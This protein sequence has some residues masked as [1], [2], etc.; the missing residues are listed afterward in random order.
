MSKK[1]EIQAVND[2]LQ[3]LKDSWRIDIGTVSDG[4]HT[5]TELYEHRYHLYI[6]LCKSYC[7][8]R[9]HGTILDKTWKQKFTCNKSYKHDDWSS[10][11]WY[12][13]MQ[14]ETPHWQISYHLPNALWNTCAFAS[15]LEKSKTWDGHTSDD[16]LEILLKI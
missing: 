9:Y 1:T 11:E 8:T 16:V 14:L 2:N 3:D 12:F 13:I 4:D 6:A 10:F 15:T 7:T 5:F